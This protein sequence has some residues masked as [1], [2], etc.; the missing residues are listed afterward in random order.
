MNQINNII[1]FLH[2]KSG[3]DKKT[4]EEIDDLEA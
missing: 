4:M 1:I 3:R 2:S